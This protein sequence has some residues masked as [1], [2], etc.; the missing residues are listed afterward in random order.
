MRLGAKIGGRYRLTKNLGGGSGQVWLAHDDA[1]RRYVVLKRVRGAD[2]SA[3]GFDR[4]RTEAH[5]LGGVSHPHVVTLYDAVRVGHYRWAT[6]WLVMEYAPGG[7][8]DGRPP[9]PP[10]LAAGIGAQI[11]GALATLH[12]KDV[13]HG[14]VKPGNVVLAADGAA[15]LADF[16]AAYRFG[17]VTPA[18]GRRA[19][20]VAYTPGYAA[21]EV[22]LHRSPEPASDVF[23]LA[24]MVHTLV[25]G[26]PPRYEVYQGEE[27]AE[28]VV[29]PGVGPLREALTAMLR[30][31]AEDRPTAAEAGELL[32][33]VAGPPENLPP[34]PGD[35]RITRADDAPGTPDRSGRKRIAAVAVAVTALALAV[36]AGAW[37]GTWGSAWA[38]ALGTVR[39]GD[40]AASASVIGDHR[41]ADPCALTDSAALSRFG[42]PVLEPAYGNF[43]RCDVILRDLRDTTPDAVVDVEVEFGD[44]GRPELAGPVTTTGR[45]S[46]A[47]GPPDGGEC[48][49]T[50]LPAGDDAYVTITA[51]PVEG[52]RAGVSALCRIA[53]VAV[54]SATKVLNDVPAGGRTPRRSPPLPAE[55]L[56]NRDACALLTP[57]ALEAVPGVDASDPEAG[58][59]RW[60]CSWRSTTSDLWVRL[61]FDRGPTPTAADGT[62]VELAGHSAVIA[63]PDDEGPHTAKVQVVHRSFTVRDGYTEVETVNVVVG[64]GSRSAQQLSALATDLARAAA[65]SA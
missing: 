55:S 39:G 58:F 63:P 50:L 46:V 51:K 45:V 56:A 22:W 7:S 28:C 3:A 13:V 26:R 40:V 23:S 41:T 42:R 6:S 49:R 34:L 31:A 59:G 12:T 15:K 60:D 2:D 35:P 33:T 52:T 9:L 14:D 48:D 20:R 61:F 11:A 24:A 10:A 5:A 62:P 43:D 38:W 47:Q 65:T 54:G 57:R 4:L 16:G 17:G 25:T 19:G 32:R 21:P 37:A 30:S 36:W 29:D 8:L 1:L 27:A 53:D 44:G 18:A 64:D